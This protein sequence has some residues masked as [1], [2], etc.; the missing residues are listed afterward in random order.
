MLVDRYFL[1]PTPLRF[2]MRTAEVSKTLSQTPQ[3]S[4]IFFLSLCCGCLVLAQAQFCF[5]VRPDIHPKNP[6]LIRQI[7]HSF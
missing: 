2:M 7:P 3:R 6:L 4:I 1:R 5:F